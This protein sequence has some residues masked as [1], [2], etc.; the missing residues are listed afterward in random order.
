MY[1]QLEQDNVDDCK[2]ICLSVCQFVCLS[3]C[4]STVPQQVSYRIWTHLGCNWASW[5]P[6][7]PY[8]FQMGA[9]CALWTTFAPFYP[10]GVQMSLISAKL[11]ERNSAFTTNV[12]FSP[13]AWPNI[14]ILHCTPPVEYLAPFIYTV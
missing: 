6:Y 9:M 5:C 4:R 3:V 11:V 10:N 8:G 2:A 14:Q 12:F 1:V 7:V 13:H